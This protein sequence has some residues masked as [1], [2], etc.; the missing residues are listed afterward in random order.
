MARGDFIP[1][2]NEKA[3]S[4]MGFL[5]DLYVS[6]F[7]GQAI[8]QAYVGLDTHRLDVVLDSGVNPQQQAYQRYLVTCWFRVFISQDARHNSVCRPLESKIQ[9]TVIVDEV[10]DSIA[11][12]YNLVYRELKTKR[13]LDGQDV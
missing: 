3:I 9:V 4:T 8:S 12:V 11:E 2:F 7:T 10:P 6:P 13:F 5:T 1:S